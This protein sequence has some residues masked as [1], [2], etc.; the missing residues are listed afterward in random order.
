MRETELINLFAGAEQPVPLVLRWWQT[1]D[2]RRD[3]SSTVLLAVLAR[4]DR[5]GDVAV[6][7]GIFRVGQEWASR[8]AAEMASL[9]AALIATKT[10]PALAL[11]AVLLE[12]A[13]EPHRA[14][15]LLETVAE[16]TDGEIRA[17]CLLSRAR[18]CS[19][20]GDR[21]TA[22]E[23][24]AS[25]VR[26]STSARTLA[27][28]DTLL[29]QIERDGELPCRRRCRIGIVGSVTLDLL[30]PPLHA[31][32]LAHGVRAEFW[33]GGFG[34]YVQEVLD[35]LSGLADFKPEIVIIACDWRALSL[36]EETS[37]AAKLVE[38]KVA[39]FRQLWRECRERLHAHVIQFNFEV[40]PH[41]PYGRLSATLPG[42]MT[43][44]L[45]E[46]NR[47][48]FEA[49]SAIPGLT[50]VDV[51]QIAGCVG[52]LSWNDA[53]LWH[54]A[55]QYPAPEALP[56]LA[57]H[58]AALV[59]AVL[60]LTAKCLVLD[61]D[62]TLWGGVIGE[63]GLSNLKL[64]GLHIGEAYVTFQKY[65]AAL[66]RR[67][68]VLAVC[69]K[70][71]EADAR[72]P[73]ESHPEM[74]LKLEDITLFVAN[75]NTKDENLRHIA[76]TL[77]LGLDSLVFVDDSPVE[78]QWVRRQLPEVEV[79]DLP[80][81]PA[82]Y[83]EALERHLPFEALTL[84]EE[85]RHRVRTYRENQ[86]REVLRGACAEVEEFLA[87]LDM[88]VELRPFDEANL[89]RIAQLINKTNQFNLTTR[90]LTE[91]QV[92]SL[93]GAKGVYT[94]AMR[95][96]DRYG[97]YGLTGVLIARAEGSSLRID[98]WL[99]S[100]R[101]MGRG[102]EEAMMAAL[103]QTARTAG[104]ARLIGEFIPSAKNGVVGDLFKRLGFEPLAD[105]AMAYPC[106]V[107]DLS[108]DPIRFPAW[109]RVLSPTPEAA[110]FAG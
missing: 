3:E 22:G 107:W 106:Y 12:G 27:N 62:G 76:R 41:G 53:A 97:D 65:V 16:C 45:R 49:G 2:V 43:R 6:L 47:A 28:A 80:E 51:D 100:C 86:E 55:K 88:V 13:G 10:P 50:I 29:R 73:F 34:Q 32:C 40:P 25:A 110:W 67:G 90:R 37:D 63:D 105:A 96:R 70:N 72:Q 4:C 108:R 23:A 35:P 1:A 75:W 83:I 68:I 57:R 98:D 84:S 26:A 8:H 33:A 103:M 61:L 69:S 15:E 11:A 48:L 56:A 89:P 58:L 44:V 92:A 91:S 74:V 79:V 77:N 85:D 94:Q 18:N 99:M 24:W 31:V 81:D 30:V 17:L 93:I 9:A 87:A 39:E 82:L 5:I 38:A 20:A 52:K 64:G 102:V 54:A 7:R 36:S 14:A 60:G 19:Q 78:R 109:M 46:I 101:V 42:G 21:P 95:L 66:K 71:N 104:F 59:R